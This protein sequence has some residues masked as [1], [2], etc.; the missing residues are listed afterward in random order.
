[1]FYVM[2]AKL[3]SHN[4][5]L[6]QTQIISDNSLKLNSNKIPYNLFRRSEQKYYQI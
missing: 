6:I 2:S 4:F 5:S 3:K 1:M